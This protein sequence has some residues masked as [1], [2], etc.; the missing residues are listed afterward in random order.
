[1]SATGYNAVFQAEGG[2][3]AYDT[4][5]RNRVELIRWNDG[6]VECA[7][8]FSA[9]SGE[10]VLFKVREID[11]LIGLLRQAKAALAAAA[12]AGVDPGE[13]A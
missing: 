12:P 11:E 9:Y 5:R 2:P 10:S 6:P 3:Q 13:A 7:D 8:V 4:R 1:M